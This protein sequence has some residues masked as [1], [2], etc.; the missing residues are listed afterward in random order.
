MSKGN[1]DIFQSQLQLIGIEL[2]AAQTVSCLEQL[3]AMIAAFTSGTQSRR[4]PAPL[5]TSDR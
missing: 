5:K 2:V 1:L 4:W 3:S